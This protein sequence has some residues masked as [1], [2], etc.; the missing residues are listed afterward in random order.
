M[1]CDNFEAIPG[2]GKKNR[3]QPAQP[4]FWQKI[5]DEPAEPESFGKKGFLGEN[6]QCGAVCCSVVRCGAVCCSDF[7]AMLLQTYQQ[8]FCSSVLQ[9]V[10]VCCNM[11]QRAAVCC[12]VLQCVA[13]CCSVLQRAAVCC[14]ALHVVAHSTAKYADMCYIVL[15]RI[16][17]CCSMLQYV[18]VCC[19]L[20][21]ADSTGGVSQTRRR[22]VQ[23]VAVFCSML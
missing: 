18:A 13:V 12:S 16:A 17:A 11:L 23:H 6:H 20:C 22:V 4:H 9:S 7:D 5:R 21:L 1:R 3:V 14:K 8:L 10:A 2:R 19:S 15:Q